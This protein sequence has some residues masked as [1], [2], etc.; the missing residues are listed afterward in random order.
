MIVLANGCFDPLHPGHVAHL[1]EARSFGT[2]LIVALTSD[3]GVR[4]EKGEKRPNLEFALR[5]FMLEELRC[6]TQVISSEYGWD[7]IRVV[8]PD[9]FAKGGDYTIE[10]TP[11][12]TINACLEVGA[13]IRFTEAPRFGVEELVRRLTR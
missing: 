2:F 13:K 5:K 9:I 11:R 4:R 10:T 7:A 6:V 3:A 1:K 8:R 12:E